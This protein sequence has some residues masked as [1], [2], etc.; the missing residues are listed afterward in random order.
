MD[1]KPES[2]KISQKRTLDNDSERQEYDDEV[3]A[4]NRLTGALGHADDTY[5]TFKNN[6]KY[7]FNIQ[8]LNPGNK[9]H[10][11]PEGIGGYKVA[12]ELAMDMIDSAAEDVKQ[13]ASGYAD[14]M[15][16]FLGYAKGQMEA[17]LSDAEEII[18]SLQAAERYA[19]AIKD[20]KKTNT[21][22][23]YLKEVLS[24]ERPYLEEVLASIEQAKAFLAEIQKI[25]DYAARK[26][27]ELSAK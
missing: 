13:P 14:A 11:I 27:A 19:Q 17:Q 3:A 26:E 7:R 23:P 6:E 2:E 4:S 18:N 20:S 21:E 25:E 10:S 8:D 1:T 12:F 9:R 15:N 24:V 5:E 16:Q 22:Q